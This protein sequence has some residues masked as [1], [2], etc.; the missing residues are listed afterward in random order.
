[1][2]DS[3][4]AR[5]DSPSQSWAAITG[6]GSKERAEK[7]MRS[8]SEH[9]VRNED[10]LVLLFDPPF[11]TSHLQSGD[12][13]GHLLGVDENGSLNTLGVL[14][15][16]MAWARLGNGA[17][18]V[19]LLRLMTPVNLASN[20][21]RYRV[22]PYVV[23]ED[24]YRLQ[25]K[26]GMG[27]WTWFTGA[28]GWMYRIWLEEVLGFRLHG[29][30]LSLDPVIPPEWPGF[31]IRYRYGKTLYTIQIRNPVGVTHGI[32]KVEMDGL[33]CRSL[34]LSL[35]DDGVDHHVNVRM[36]K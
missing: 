20:P 36:G 34:D 14:W 25:G 17:E 7:A 22:E 32:S 29:N 12:I 1:S 23:A 10:G 9:L 18:A 2:K 28:A 19:R 8:V 27:G 33:P 15:A 24:I 21:E 5:I 4:Q 16:A 35:V 26:V 30:T 13:K 11:D 31:T 3:P 6:S